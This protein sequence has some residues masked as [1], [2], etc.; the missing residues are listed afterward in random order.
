MVLA[1]TEHNT[2]FE[3]VVSPEG[4]LRRLLT[5]WNTVL[6]MSSMSPRLAVDG[7]VF[8]FRC[9]YGKEG[10]VFELADNTIIIFSQGQMFR[11]E[12]P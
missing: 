2:L 12:K 6:D 7:M 9:G 10:A 1:R 8:R 4:R 3:V 11:A 5:L